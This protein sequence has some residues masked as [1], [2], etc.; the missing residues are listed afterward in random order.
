MHAGLSD[1]T[2]CPSTSLL[3]ASPGTSKKEEPGG[4]R[5]SISSLHACPRPSHILGAG[6]DGIQL[7]VGGQCLLALG[8][9]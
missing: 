8:K 2:Q 1:A 5:Q 3:S 7:R 4:C 6:V 9:V